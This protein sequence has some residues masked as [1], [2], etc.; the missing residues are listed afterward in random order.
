[1]FLTAF[2]S[3]FFS[4]H[5]F[6]AWVSVIAM[7]GCVI[8]G[9]CGAYLGIMLARGKLYLGCPTCDAKSFVSAGHRG[10]MT[11]DCPHCGEI[12]LKLG[13]LSKLQ[14]TTAKEEREERNYCKPISKSPFHA[15]LQF[16]IPF[17][18][19]F[20]PVVASIIAASVIHQF[21]FFYLVIPG[22]WCYFVAGFT[23]E[24]IYAG[25][26]SSRHGNIT[27]KKSPIRFWG[28]IGLWSAFYL[29]AAA[30]PIG[31]ARQESRKEKA[32]S[33]LISAPVP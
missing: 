4:Q 22:F 32:K 14:A 6:F 13:S 11:L 15:P 33:E 18:I 26:I 9:L 5:A 23:L 24:A 10:V 27:R 2:V 12:R 8:L 1:M 21:S 25:Y 20:S 7:A 28:M 17:L 16:R 19:V 3:Q 29:F 30:F 31:Y